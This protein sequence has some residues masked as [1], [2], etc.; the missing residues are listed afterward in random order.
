MGN[1]QVHELIEFAKPSR[2]RCDEANGE[3]VI[4]GVKYLGAKSVNVN[5]DGANNHY[6]LAGRLKSESLFNGL[7]GHKSPQEPEQGQGQSHLGREQ[8]RV[9]AEGDGQ[10]EEREDVGRG[11][12]GSL[13]YGLWVV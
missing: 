9:E 13:R 5:S 6:P 2:V 3:I 7:L 1:V 10:A 4:E 11:P 12:L 8:G